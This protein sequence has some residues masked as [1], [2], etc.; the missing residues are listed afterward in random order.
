MEKI[1]EDNK[2]DIVN[3]ILDQIDDKL[4]D[5]QQALTDINN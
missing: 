4:R 5:F 3:N 1:I 2:Q